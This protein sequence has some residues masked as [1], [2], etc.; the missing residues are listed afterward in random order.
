N[1]LI[2]KKSNAND[3]VAPDPFAHFTIDLYRQ[4]YAVL[5]RAAVTVR[6]IVCRTQKRR[7]RVGVSIVKLDSVK[8]GFAGSRR[9]RS[10]YF[11]KNERKLANVLEMHVRHAL[12]ITKA[13][14]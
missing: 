2:T 6:S 14:R 7:H 3:V 8:Y 1:D 4:P 9:R 5:T 13:K 11:G 12:A 10:K